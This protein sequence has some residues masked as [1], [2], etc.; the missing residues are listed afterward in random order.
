MRL[1]SSYRSKAGTQGPDQIGM[2]GDSGCR[3]SLPYFSNVGFVS[4]DLDFITRYLTSYED[5][6]RLHKKRMGLNKHLEAYD[7]LG[8]A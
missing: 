7:L 3:R 6:Q 1:S 4:D 2:R 8:N 5:D